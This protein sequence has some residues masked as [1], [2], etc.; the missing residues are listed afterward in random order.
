[1]PPAIKMSTIIIYLF[2]SKQIVFYL[3]KYSLFLNNSIIYFVLG[4]TPLM[5]APSTTMRDILKNHLLDVQ[6]VGPERKPWKFNGPWDIYGMYLH[7]NAVVTLLNMLIC[8]YR[9]FG[10]WL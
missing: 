10:V 3:I 9:S 2:L 7:S 5:L 8:L 6:N 4:Q 1:M